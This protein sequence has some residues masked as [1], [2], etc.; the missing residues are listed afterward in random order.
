MGSA[1]VLNLAGQFFSQAKLALL[2]E[3]SW[4]SAGHTA[5]G[6]DEFSA[7]VYRHKYLH[8]PG[9]YPGLTLK[10]FKSLTRTV[11]VSTESH[12]SS[13]G[14]VKGPPLS[15]HSFR[16]TLLG[17]GKVHLFLSRVTDANPNTH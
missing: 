16:V 4:L 11:V 13:V 3:I 6:A 7:Q 5:A 9:C 14:G 1:S 10:L 12:P 8:S 15:G 2:T 17:K